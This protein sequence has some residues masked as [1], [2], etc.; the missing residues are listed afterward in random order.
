MTTSAKLFTPPKTTRSQVED[1][2]ADIR[3]AYRAGRK[4]RAATAAILQGAGTTRISVDTVSLSL[5]ARARLAGQQVALSAQVTETRIEITRVSKTVADVVSPIQTQ[6]TPE[7]WAVG[8][9]SGILPGFVYRSDRPISE[10]EYMRIARVIDAGWA[11]FTP[12]EFLGSVAGTGIEVVAILGD[13]SEQ[14][15]ETLRLADTVDKLARFNDQ[16]KQANASVRDLAL[17]TTG[18]QPGSEPTT[19]IG[20]QLAFDH[21]RAMAPIQRAIRETV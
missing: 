5:E 1:A 8:D 18:P 16:L 2:R 13:D 3:D 12:M 9:T 15:A 10:A 21:D 6:L 11:D 19:T 4:T 14:F 20:K 7:L 17:D